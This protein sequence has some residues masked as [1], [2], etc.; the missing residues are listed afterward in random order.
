MSGDR[1]LPVWLQAIVAIAQIVGAVAIPIVLLTVGNSFAQRQSET[2][3]AIEDQRA[4][5]AALQA[6][7]NDIGTL[8]L[9]KDLRTT[10]DVDTRNLARARTLTMLDISSPNRKPR[11]LEFLV[12][13]ELIQTDA[14]DQ[15]PVISLK[16]ADLH[17]VDMI[18]R[19]LLRNT[20]LDRANLNRA[21]LIDAKLSNANLPKAHLFRAKLRRTILTDANLQRAF[22]IRSDLEEA[23]LTGADLTGADLTNAK[24]VSCQLTTQAESL[25]GATMPNGQKYEHWLKD[26]EGCEGS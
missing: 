11:V 3:R 20:N 19:D 1:T 18:N 12:E 25:E 13:M 17:E 24:G 22:L 16:F 2:Q 26:N 6:Y 14:P 21:R 8:L 4:Q 5:L 9:E 23:D 7:L 10:A 15:Q